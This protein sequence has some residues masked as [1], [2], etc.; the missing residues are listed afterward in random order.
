MEGVRMIT[1]TN[2]YFSLDL[3][4]DGRAEDD[5]HVVH[6]DHDVPKVDKLDP[7]LR[8]Q[9]FAVKML[10]EANGFLQNELKG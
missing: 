3:L 2:P 10:E 5:E 9:L 7:A 6:D 8:A 4:F 1:C